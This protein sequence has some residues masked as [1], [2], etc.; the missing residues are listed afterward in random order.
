M[1]VTIWTLELQGHGEFKAK[2]VE[3][4]RNMRE[5]K[6]YLVQTIADMHHVT[7]GTKAYW[8]RMPKMTLAVVLAGLQYPLN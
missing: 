2:D 6:R 4:Q 8:L 1:R 3:V 5:S 7:D